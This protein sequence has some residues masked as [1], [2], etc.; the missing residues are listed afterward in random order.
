MPDSQIG[1]GCVNAFQESRTDRKP[2][3]S[4][5]PVCVEVLPEMR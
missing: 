1:P 2:R 3:A 4:I 5:R